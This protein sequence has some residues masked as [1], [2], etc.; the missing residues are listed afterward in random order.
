MPNGRRCSAAV[1]HLKPA[2]SRPNLTLITEALVEK[3]ASPHVAQ[4]YDV[5]VY[6]NVPYVVAELIEGES[7]AAF[8]A[9]GPLRTA[10]A[11]DHTLRTS[12]VSTTSNRSWPM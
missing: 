1:A 12:V 8:L 2:L 5:A 9:R 11:L 6:N 4:V 3:I 7:L 10:D